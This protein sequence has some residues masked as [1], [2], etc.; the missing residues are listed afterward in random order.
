MDQWLGLHPAT[1]GHMGSISG[2]GTK[3]PNSHIVQEKK[4]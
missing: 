3:I 1:A 2:W 4:N